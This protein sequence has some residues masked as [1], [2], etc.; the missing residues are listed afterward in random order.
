MGDYAVG[1]RVTVF[2]LLWDDAHP[3]CAEGQYAQSD[4][5][6]YLGS[7]SDGGFARYVIAAV[8]NLIR[9]PDA[10]SMEAAAMTEPAAV[11][12]R[13]APVSVSGIQ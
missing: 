1:D 6:D 9:L 2:P 8:R 10:V 5:Y 3:A 11:V 4:G 7:R 12:P 13:A